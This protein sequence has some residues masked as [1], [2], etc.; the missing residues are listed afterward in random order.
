MRGWL[1]IIGVVLIF[2]GGLYLF[3]SEQ[4]VLNTEETSNYLEEVTKK[5]ESNFQFYH[6]GLAYTTNTNG[7]VI[8]YKQ[9][10]LVGKFGFGI[11]GKFNNIP[12]KFTSQNFTWTWTESNHTVMEE[13]WNGSSFEDKTF[14][15]RT[16]TGNNNNPKFNWTQEWS[17][18]PLG[19][20]KTTQT[21]TNNLNGPLTN[22]KIWYV[23]TVEE[24][25]K[26]SF[27]GNSR[28]ANAS[29][30]FHLKGLFNNITP[31]IDLGS[32]EFR[33]IDLI[34]NNFDI[35]DLYL[36]NGS[37]IGIDGTLI[38]AVAVTKGSRVFMNGTTITLDPEVT[39]FKSPTNTTFPPNQFFSPDNIKVSD[40]AYA[41]QVNIG[42]S[43]TVGNFSFEDDI[44]MDGTID[45]IQINMEGKGTCA[46]GCGKFIGA[47][48]NITLSW[49]GGAT[50][51]DIGM[52][53]FFNSD[54]SDDIRAISSATELWGRTWTPD[55][56]NNSN[57]RVKIN[58]LSEVSPATGIELDHI[59]VQIKFSNPAPVMN[60]VEPNSSEGS[61]LGSTL[62]MNATVNNSVP[63]VAC[64]IRE[65][66]N[67][68]RVDHELTETGIYDNGLGCYGAIT[69]TGNTTGFTAFLEGRSAI[70]EISFLDTLTYTSVNTEP[71]ITFNSPAN[72]STGHDSSVILNFTVEDNESDWLEVKLFATNET[73][74]ITESMLIHE[75]VRNGTFEFN[76]SAHPIFGPMDG[77]V[78]YYHLDNQADFGENSTHIFDFMGINNGTVLDGFPSIK[79]T[80]TINQE[81]PYLSQLQGRFGGGFD[82]N[83]NLSADGNLINIGP[84]DTF[85][86]ICNTASGCSFSTWSYRTSRE[87]SGR[88][89]ISR[90]GSSGSD[91]R[92]MYLQQTS[93]T[94]NQTWFWLGKNGNSGGDACL[95]RGGDT[96]L[97]EWHHLVGVYNNQ[98]N[99]AILYIDG[100]LNATEDCSFDSIDALAWQKNESMVIGGWQ[101]FKLPYIGV[102]DEVSLWNKALTA[103]EVADMHSLQ[104]GKYFWQV[105]VSDAN[106]TGFNVSEFTVGSALTCTVDCSVT[107]LI[108]A[109]LDCGGTSLTFIG[110]DRTTDN[111]TITLGVNI[112]NFDSNQW[113]MEQ[114]LVTGIETILRGV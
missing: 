46:F 112:T 96:T 99:Q 50:F 32:V 70:D 55:E 33:Y 21:L 109:N 107:N 84:N 113:E 10:N 12:Q 111:V 67:G 40:D 77:L 74:E 102:I 52:D 19:G 63:I 43:M 24:G 62:F 91:R 30:D 34:E 1:L 87:G 110:T 22:T 94:N 86:D 103:E 72:A 16:F 65:R 49:D 95:A 28:I 78:S 7:V 42:Q 14:L 101:E 17:T 66:S 47:T 93:T 88:F 71:F 15:V 81:F 114:C 3:S 31:H 57:F 37:I 11:T 35:T 64:V 8:V 61:V 83:G 60:Y 75:F 6:G 97:N 23:N 90:W 85:A 5:S 106:L 9:N 69:I 59:E 25:D 18:L 80:P 73:S 56:L 38:F 58:H 39:G 104:D 89:T 76:F 82:F 100:V 105:N 108:E 45:G 13:V 41:A 48:E 79:A 2:L 54:G 51:T 20:M 53:A 29:Q 44:A 4:F 26:V 36:G 68:S 98:T 27:A 92:F